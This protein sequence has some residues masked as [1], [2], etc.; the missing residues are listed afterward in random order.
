M[1]LKI[2]N[3][4]FSPP[5]WMTELKRLEAPNIAGQKTEY[6]AWVYYA[7]EKVL[8]RLH[9]GKSTFESYVG[10]EQKLW[11]KQVQFIQ[12][13]NWNYDVINTTDD[14]IY[15]LDAFDFEWD[16]WMSVRFF[17]NI[18]KTI[19]VDYDWEEFWDLI[20]LDIS[21]SIDFTGADDKIKKVNL[22]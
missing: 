4:F 9:P 14:I 17:L 15:N 11:I 12:N 16:R 19:F 1:M 22:Q 18:E 7:N 21:K 8:L 6:Y 3:V 10:E 2:W 13:I 20:E 5:M